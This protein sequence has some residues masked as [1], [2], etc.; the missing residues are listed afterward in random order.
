MTGVQAAFLAGLTVVMCAIVGFAVVVVVGAARDGKGAVVDSRLMSRMLSGRG[1]DRSEL[2]RWVFYA[3]RISGFA[4]FAFLC[5]HVLD[6]SLYAA[7]SNLFSQVHRIYG[8]GFMRVLECGLLLGI[9]FHTF[10]GLRL[11]AVDLGDWGL[12]TSRRALAVSVA[13]TA[14]LGIAGSVVILGPIFT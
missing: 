6:V 2:D 4:I 3:H 5:L 7:S 14:L 13:L 12:E 9:L 11:L 8:N 10:N 1:K